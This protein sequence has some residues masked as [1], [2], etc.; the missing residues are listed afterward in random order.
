M[1]VK[2]TNDRHR[3]QNIADARFD[4]ERMMS[5]EIDGLGD[6]IYA[7]LNNAR[8]GN[9]GSRSDLLAHLIQYMR[10]V[11]NSSVGNEFQ[12]KFGES[13]IVQQSIAVAME[14]FDD[15]KGSSAGELY[16]WVG[17]ILKNELRQNQ[18]A[19]R[20]K[21]RDLYR[22]RSI[23]PQEDSVAK[24]IP[25]HDPH[26]TPASDAIRCENE[27]RL[28]VAMQMLSDEHGQ[29]IRLRNWQK[30]SFKE[31]GRRMNRTENAATKLWYRALIQLRQQLEV[32]NDD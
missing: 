7:L 12:A 31:I 32:S 30:L 20:S 26:L 8:A 2:K 9:A 25:I 28:E 17:Q 24:K 16:A 22:E 18:R 3:G 23:E 14:K 13:D 5:A 19:L 1:L 10:I 21:K 29:V 4:K 11:A 6:S 15:F 27:R